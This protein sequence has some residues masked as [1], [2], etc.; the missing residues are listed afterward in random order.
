M[1]SPPSPGDPG[2]ARAAADWFRALTATTNAAVFVHQEGLVRF[3]N[4]GAAT[5]LG[6]GPADLPGT[7]FW[8]LVHPDSRDMARRREQDRE[9]GVLGA[10]RCELRILARDGEP[11]W[12][13]LT[14]TTVELDGRPAVLAV[15]VDVTERRLSEQALRE[16]ERRISDILE[17]VQLLAV[18]R[19]GSGE[20]TFANPYF[21]ELVG[22][23]EEDVVGRDWFDTFVPLE[24]RE[25]QRT[26][27]VESTAAGMARPH[28]ESE[29]LTR[30]EER[31]LIAWTHT[32]LHDLE[33][34]AVGT[35]S[36]GSDITDRKRVE[37]QL[38]HDALH[39]ALTGLPNRALFLHH[40]GTAFARARRRPGRLLGVLF[41]DLD[42]F[43]VV[44]DSLGHVAGDQLLVEFSR[45][46]RAAVRPGD[47][48]ARL[49]GDEFT[50]LLEDLD[51]AADAGKVA[52]RIHAAVAAPFD[53]GGGHEVFATVSVGI[54]LS[55]RTYVRAEDLLR[56]ADTAMY[57]A[58]EGGRSRTRVFD[59]SMHSRAMELLSLE[60]DLR[61]AVERESFLLHYQPIVE[62]ASGRVA[63]LEA[64]TRWEHSDR[65][66][67]SPVEFVELAE[68]T[69]LILE[70]GRFALQRACVD[71]QAWLQA[72]P[73]ELEI[74]VNISSRQFSQPN[75]VDQVASALTESGL[76]PSRLK[77]EI[78]ESVIMENAESA[79][80]MLSRLKE[81][82][83]RVSIDDFGTGYSSLGYLL[84]FPADT[85]KIDRS[86]VSALAR[87][88]RNQQLVE[89]IVSLSRGLGM[90]VVAEGVETEEQRALL[91]ALGCRYGQGFLF[92][93]PMDRE[94][95]TALLAAQ[96]A[97]TP[98]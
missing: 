48:V 53:L 50:I 15:A 73:L 18:L 3:A 30:H 89:A 91:Q 11:R 20:I 61:R 80:S 36:I 23:E 72:F 68:E 55:S 34:R 93:R 39:D 24:L 62:L 17:N 82:G 90:D 59:T 54:A 1:A 13:D 71:M 98:G 25:T 19:D 37:Q 76:P 58:K 9:R 87:G 47:L 77:L 35:A 49:G 67:V 32:V 7:S 16:A 21:L 27:Y 6:S 33:G 83:A 57:Q 60:S 45:L 92:S 12:V 74:S 96:A 10:E 65:G 14:S 51:D 85:I 64:L 8:D 38:V 86:F 22:L 66:L 41:V 84:R 31:R 94:R 69:G 78:T 2:A 43:K 4:P 81:L 95:T 42:R 52:D 88:R 75:L 56:D 70:I 97:A 79:I 46:L 28:D 63:G 29:V 44:N 5:L 40:L 26:A